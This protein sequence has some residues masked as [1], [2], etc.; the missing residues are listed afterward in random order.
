MMGSRFVRSAKQPPKDRE[1]AKPK[2]QLDEACKEMRERIQDERRKKESAEDRERR[3]SEEE[4]LMEQMY[5][6]R[7]RDAG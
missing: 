6:P 7:W 3:R 4:A 1:H 5:G 2:K